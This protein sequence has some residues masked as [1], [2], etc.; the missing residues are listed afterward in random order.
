MCFCFYFIPPHLLHCPTDCDGER[1]EQRCDSLW[2][3]HGTLQG[4]EFLQAQRQVD[5]EDP[6]GAPEKEGKGNDTGDLMA[7]LEAPLKDHRLLREPRHASYHVN[8]LQI[9]D[10]LI[11]SRPAAYNKDIDDD[12]RLQRFFFVECKSF[13]VSCCVLVSKSQFTN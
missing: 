13:G 6:Q 12:Q 5:Y 9:I 1:L 11:L 7:L 8:L 10:K 3:L 4:G 2:R